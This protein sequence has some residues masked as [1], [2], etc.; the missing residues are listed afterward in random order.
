MAQKIEAQIDQPETLTQQELRKRE[1][2]R[3]EAEER[4]FAELIRSPLGRAV[5]HSRR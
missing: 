1:L 5:M 3:E 2:E 4:A